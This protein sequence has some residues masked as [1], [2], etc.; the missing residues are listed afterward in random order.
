MVTAHTGAATSATITRGVEGT[1]A[2]QHLQGTTW[3]HV[4]TYY[5][6]LQIVANAAA[7]P[8]TNIYQGQM[9]Y[10]QDL[11]KYVGRSSAG[12]WQDLVSMGAWTTFTPTLT[13]SA[14]VTKTVTYARYS[15]IGR[16]INV[17]VE[18]AVTGAGTASN[19]VKVGLPVAAVSSSTTRALGVGFINDTSA[20]ALYKGI[21]VPNS[22]TDILFRQTN[23][24][25]QGTLGT[26]VF[27]AGLASGDTVTFTATYEA[28]T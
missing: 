15:R 24:T 27:T 7:L 10:Q 22:T 21:V 11:D 28:A 20:G 18:L 5:D 23:D 25:G 2:R 13:Q 19:D 9:A 14:T 4:A 6:D 1:S 26:A 3:R 16:T 12:V 8:S 17:V